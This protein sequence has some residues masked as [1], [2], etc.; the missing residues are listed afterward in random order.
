MEWGLKFGVTQIVGRVTS[1]ASAA[2]FQ[3][4][5]LILLL[6]A[7]GGL[8]SALIVGIFC[9]DAA[10]HGTDVMTRAFH[11]YHGVL[12]LRGPVFKAAAAVVVISFGGSAGPEGPIVALGAAIGSTCGRMFGVLP[13]ERRTLLIAGCA[14][15]V[16]AIFRC[17]LGGALFAVSIPYSEPDHEAEAIVP[18]FV[19]SVTGYSVY[20]ALWGHGEF[21]IHGA[22]RLVFSSPMEL[23]PFLVLGPM[24]G[25]ITIFF[26]ATF[27]FVEGIAAR[28]KRLPRWVAPATGGLLTGAVACYLPQVM[29]ARYEFLQGAFDGHLFG[30]TAA[31]WWWW[32]ALF[33]AV[34]IAKSVATGFTVASGAQAECLDQ[35][36]PLAVRRGRAWGPC[37]KLSSR[38]CFRSSCDRR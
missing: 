15:G 31:S 36:W 18:A 25:L 12:G 10:G 6:P 13:S 28:M 17:P 32:A 30:E 7:L 14:A 5:L 9:P 19:A 21:V 1:E 3:P 16:G 2:I 26:G 22:H 27:R 11:H 24:C 23:L 37:A 33:G 4:R 20:L 38:A 34:A 8:L 29:D 35:R